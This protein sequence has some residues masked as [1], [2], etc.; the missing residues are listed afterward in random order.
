[1]FEEGAVLREILDKIIDLATEKFG[2]E[3]VEVRVQKLCKTMLTLK[4]KNVEAAKQGI[5]NGAA[6]RVLVNGAWGF[7]SVGML[8]P[9]TLTDA[10]SDA[11][12]MA[13]AASSKLKMPIKTC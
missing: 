1:M 3:Y 5:E 6:V 8:D 12:K 9:K 11:C 13:K 7:A 4:E 2:A 10:V